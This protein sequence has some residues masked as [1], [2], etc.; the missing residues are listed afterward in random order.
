MSILGQGNLHNVFSNSRRIFGLEN[1]DNDRIDERVRGNSL[2]P[3]L[4]SIYGDS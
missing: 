2:G 1:A 4:R 3:P